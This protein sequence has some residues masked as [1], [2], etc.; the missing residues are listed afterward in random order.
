MNITGLS[1]NCSTA[2][3]NTA[4]NDS[5]KEDEDEKTEKSQPSP[6]HPHQQYIEVNNEIPEQT[7]KRRNMQTTPECLK[8][9]SS[10]DKEVSYHQD[11][12]T[13]EEVKKP[14][15][16]REKEKRR[17]KDLLSKSEDKKSKKDSKEGS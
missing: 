12:D 8:I 6:Q 1:R 13:E 5:K 11:Q 15:G 16:D 7:Q 4:T 14:D 3:N 2:S 10:N 9:L 17:E